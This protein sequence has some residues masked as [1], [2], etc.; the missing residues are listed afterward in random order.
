MKLLVSI[1]V[2]TIFGA[3]AFMPA[4]VSAST[5]KYNN[6]LKV[7][8]VVLPAQY[9]IV[10]EQGTI[11]EISSN[12]TQDVKPRVYLHTIHKDNVRPLTSEIYR[13]YRRIVPPGQA[14]VGVLY[15]HAPIVPSFIRPETKSAKEKPR[16][17]SLL[18]LL[19]PP[20]QHQ[21]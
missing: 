10:D 13:Q 14:K 15:Q 16:S 9:I 8:G 11:L 5:P 4:P 2:L 1:L 21:V 3:L 18:L 19:S 20:G 6:K 7:T 12:T 17:L